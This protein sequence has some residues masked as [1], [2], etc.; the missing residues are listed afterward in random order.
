MRDQFST[1]F[2]VFKEI[3][4]RI[5]AAMDAALERNNADWNIR[6]TC[7]ACAYSLKDEPQL[8]FSMF[9]TIDGNSSLK[10]IE[11]ATRMRDESGKVVTS[12]SIERRDGRQLR[13]GGFYLN[14]D[15]VDRYKDEVRNRTRGKGKA[16]AKSEA[17]A[18]PIDPTEP[19]TCVE[20]WSNLA[21]DSEKRTWGIFDETGIFAAACRHGFILLVCDMI[22][23]GE[24]CVH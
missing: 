19:N 4:H 7:P 24:L 5:E 8:K 6:N 17:A 3:Q 9:V 11:R 21:N 23:S 22:K 18:L 14:A 13:T 1:A 15:E 12:D 16:S 20:R 10:R 2:D